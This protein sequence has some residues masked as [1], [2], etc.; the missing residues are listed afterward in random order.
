MIAALVQLDNDQNPASAEVGPSGN[1]AAAEAPLMS[2]GPTFNQITLDPYLQAALDAL[3][4]E[5]RDGRLQLIQQARERAEQRAERE[6]ERR[7]RQAEAERA[8]RQAQ[9][10]HELEVLQRG[11]NAP[12]ARTSEPSSV[13]TPKPRPEHFPVMEKDGDLDTFLRAF[14]KACRQYQ[15]PRDQWARYLT[16]GLKGKAL[17]AFASLP[18]EADDDYDAIKQALIAKYRLTPEV[19]RKK[20]RHLQRGPHDSYSDVVQGL[21][22]QFDQWIH[23]LSV[24]SF[25]QLRDLMIKDQFLHLCPAEV[26]QFILDRE[27]TN[28][29]KAAQ[30]A[31]N[32]EA[33]RKPETRRPVAT[34][35]KGGKPATNPSAPASRPSGG[36]VPVAN[37]RLAT[38]KRE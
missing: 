20:F 5:D 31:D 8:E 30:I 29:D 18:P 3:P 11:G 15:L 19:Y 27:P 32:Y 26:R 33:N 4:A 16:P 1:G 7:E 37:K 22:T 14:E 21:R 38:D 34:S 10:A 2:A 28:A 23:G 36:P 12:T 6:A 35:W 24:E 9:R 25:E 13:Q 17:E